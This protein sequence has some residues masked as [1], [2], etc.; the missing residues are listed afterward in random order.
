MPAERHGRAENLRSN[1]L[2]M[3]KWLRSRTRSA[4]K[5]LIVR[6]VRSRPQL[7]LEKIGTD[8]GGWT[9][10]TAVIREDWICY[11]GGVGE[12][13][14]F[15]DGLIERFGC[16]V[17]AF[18]PTPRAIAF[19]QGRT[20]SE[21]LFHFLAVGLWSDDTTLKFYAP[22]DPA[23][24][25]HSV[26]NLQRTDKYFEAP[27]RSLRTLMREL[28][29][30]RIDLLK[31]DIEG[32]EHRVVRSMLGSGIHPLVLCLEIDQPVRPWT[33]WTT[34]R[35]IKSAGYALVA[36]DHWNLTF[37]QHAAIARWSSPPTT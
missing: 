17:Y 16:S 6:G 3:L 1:A 14:S 10:P 21:P 29:H 36:V 15:D 33:F 8:Y 7:G 32:A 4:T 12:D 37:I 26:V 27:C 19:V 25:S 22:K 13:I 30:D 11:S 5:H 34:V 18:D 20:S 35:R 2:R 24:V 9:V 28:G 31:I 23:H